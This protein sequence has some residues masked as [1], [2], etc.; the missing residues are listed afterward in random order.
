VNK[1]PKCNTIQN[2]QETLIFPAKN[3]NPT[4][5]PANFPK[6]EEELSETSRN[7]LNVLIS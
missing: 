6:N 1:I 7:K 2:E 3:N 4:K 5:L